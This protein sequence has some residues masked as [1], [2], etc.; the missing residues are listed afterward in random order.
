MSNMQRVSERDTPDISGSFVF[1]PMPPL[2]DERMTHD[3]DAEHDRRKPLSN[4][5]AKWTGA[6]AV[7]LALKGGA[8]LATDIS[9]GIEQGKAEFQDDRSEIHLIHTYEQENPLYAHHASFV[10]TGL[11]TKN[12]SNTALSLSQQRER[13]YQFALEYS[14]KDLDTDE[15]ARQIIDTSEQYG[16]RY[17]SLTGFSAGGP[18]FLAIAAYLHE[19][20]PELHVISITMHSS[21]LGKD[22][23][24]GVSASGIDAMDTILS[25]NEDLKYYKPGRAAVEI[26][27]RRERYMSP[28]HCNT[29][30]SPSGIGGLAAAQL[31]QIDT[32]DFLYDVR[33]VRNRLSDPDTA[34]SELVELQAQYCVNREYV[35]NL[36]IL[37]KKRAQDIQP[38]VIIYT[39]SRNTAQDSVVNVAQGERNFLDTVERFGNPYAV[40]R[41]DVGHANPVEVPQRYAEVYD[42]EIFPFIA[43]RLVLYVTRDAMADDVPAVLN[44]NALGDTA[45]VPQPGG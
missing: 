44:G 29:A 16:I 24:T 39:R 41:A 31:C 10:L 15:I 2:T 38:P 6:A 19:H 7:L 22:S 40:V 37:S 28:E 21:P 30:V 12:A 5:I 8:W 27:N 43:Q 13:G 20:A 14:N 23:L 18:I 35:R 11:N 25:I 42:K 32:D 33:D 36:E 26:Y 3:V 45:A 1:D 4:K 9:H 17:V 34:S